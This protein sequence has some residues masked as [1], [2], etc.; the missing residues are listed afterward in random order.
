MSQL[1]PRIVQYLFHGLIPY[2]IYY[3]GASPNA[4]DRK[5]WTPVHHAAKTGN[6][7]ILDLLIQNG[8][9]V[10]AQNKRKMTPLMVAYKYE[11]ADASKCVE[12]V[13]VDKH[14]IQCHLFW[15]VKTFFMLRRCAQAC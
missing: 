7:A 2:F 13:K 10:N 11:D 5:R 9:D 4:K 12:V 8:G 3:T 14:K 1:L 6:A 15:S